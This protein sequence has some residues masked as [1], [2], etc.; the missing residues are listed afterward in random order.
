ML[1][2]L[3]SILWLIATIMI[4]VCGIYFSFRLGWIHLNFKE[5][6]NAI[7]SKKDNENGISLFQSLTMSLA[8][9]IGVGSLSGIAL[10]IYLGGPGVIFWIWLTSIFCSTNAFAESVL[11]VVFRKK[12]SQKIYRGGPFYYIQD[13][14]GNKKMA[15][16]YAILILIAYIG[17]FMTIQIN[18]V[19]KSITSIMPVLPL[20]IGGILA[21]IAGVTILG[22]VKKIANTTSKLVPAMTIFYIIVCVYIIIKNN[23]MIPGI[24]S[25]IFE[26]AFNF[27]TCGVGILSTMLIGMQK[28]IFSS[29]VGLGTGSIAAVTADSDSP[30]KNGLVQIFEIHF[31]NIIIATITAFVVC[32]FDYN[33]L[34][35]ADPNGI[36]I[37]L[38]AFRYHLGS[39][40]SVFVTIIITLFG[41][42]T[43]LT[44]YYYGESSLKFLKKTNK[45][46]IFILKLI[47]VILIFSGSV[48]SSSILWNIT[49]VLVGLLAIINIYAIYSLRDIVVEEYRSYK[50]GKNKM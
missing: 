1:N 4:F 44:G 6:I 45:S 38:E 41:L 40:G 19:T 8:G 15:W 14:V 35:I 25:N 23:V 30:A 39:W 33:N 2:F 36:E 34:I 21:T 47:T 27:R 48:M 43:V 46:D 12:D 37:T 17:G 20:L 7:K 26:S 11:A 28:G 18:T 50:R 3:I 22:G 16:L 42:A 31:E 5:M 32:M 9:R 49:D 29:E 10:A 13:G 24:I